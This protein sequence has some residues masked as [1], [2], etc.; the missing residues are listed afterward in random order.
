MVQALAPNIPYDPWL[1]VPIPQA[2]GL[3]ALHVHFLVV[4]LKVAAESFELSP[5]FFF[6]EGSLESVI[7]TRSTLTWVHPSYQSQCY[8]K[9]RSATKASVRLAAFTPTT[10]WVLGTI[11]LENQTNI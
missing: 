3:K 7:P 9:F 8:F 4:E 5:F 1:D 6:F 2:L 11:R 10:E